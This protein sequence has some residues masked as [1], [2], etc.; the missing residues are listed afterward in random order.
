[1]TREKKGTAM[2][3]AK[4]KKRGQKR[5]PLSSAVTEVF[6]ADTAVLRGEGGATV[7]GCHRILYYAPERIC[8]AVGKRH[9]SVFGRGLICTAFSAGC[10]TLEGAVEGIRYCR[11][12]CQGNCP[13]EGL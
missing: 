5:L 8:L 2:K 1:M 12:S 11:A 7:Y 9:V 4:E 6:S 3:Q 10:V 13:E